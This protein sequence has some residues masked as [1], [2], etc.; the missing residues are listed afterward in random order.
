MFVAVFVGDGDGV[1]VFV[2][3]AVGVGVLVKL[4]VG[5]G[6][7][8]VTVKLASEISKKILPTA[9]IFTLPAAVPVFGIV[10]VSVPSFGVL[11]AKTTGNVSPPSNDI[12]ILTFAALTGA[13]VVFAT[14]HV[15]VCDDPP[16]YVTFVLGAV[17]LNGP[18][19]LLTFTTVSANCV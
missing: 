6:V 7:G 11:S 19:V 10:N 5:V 3:V 14:S 1:P 2:L 18:A 17:T 4:G 9:S 12:E 15:I 8:P 16:A 13:A